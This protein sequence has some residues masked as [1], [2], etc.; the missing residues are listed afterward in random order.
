[1]AI[2]AESEL[3]AAGK[4]FASGLLLVL[5]SGL[6]E[7]ENGQLIA[8]TADAGVGEDLER[9]ARF[10]GNALVATSIA[11]TGTRFVIRKGA[12]P[13][14]SEA[15]RIGERLWLYTNFHCNLSC[16]YCCVRSS[17]TAARK[18][19][20]L[21]TIRRVADEAR[22]AGVREIFLTGGEPFLRDDIG[23]ILEVCSRVMPTTVLTNGMLFAG[24]RR[25]SL[26]G[27]SRT[28][29]VFQVSVDSPTSDAHDKHRGEGTWAKAWRGVSL[30]REEGFRVRLAATVPDDAAERALTAFL[31]REGI[32]PEDRVIRRVALRGFAEAGIALARAD[33]IPEVT[34]TH[35]GVYWHP[36]GAT[37]DDFFVTLDHFPLVNAIDAVRLAYAEDRRFAT[38]LASV[39]HCA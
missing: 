24:K 5:V 32:A 17:P 1:M 26:R 28:N 19:L 22:D 18:E 37:D 9:W 3:S 10:T 39:F 13:S 2:H 34:L 12:A 15:P 21:S 30:A 38:S 27:L 35:D 6:R 8:L 31:D 14:E 20:A 36:V 11:P 29:V 33:L 23:E 7:I 4:D 16:D 25:E